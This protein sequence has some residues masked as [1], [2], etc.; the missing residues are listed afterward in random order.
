MTE[1]CI[2]CGNRQKHIFTT[3]S[4]YV[5]H[6]KYP[7]RDGHVL[8]IPIRH[9]ERIS[10]L[11]NIEWIDLFFGLKLVN[12][13]INDVYSTKSY[14]IGINCSKEAG[15]TIPHLHF[16]VVPRYAGDVE[17]PEGGIRHFL[18]NPLTEYPPR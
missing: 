15:Q 9:V 12:K 11:S 18:P 5:M 17:H 3:R 10:E 1:K 7:L 14:N 16:H 4:F 6:D 13:H 8:V 2:F